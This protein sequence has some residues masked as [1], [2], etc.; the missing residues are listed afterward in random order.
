MNSSDR[1]R[2]GLDDRQFVDLTLMGFL[3]AV[4][5][6]ADALA[7]ARCVGDRSR[8]RLGFMLHVGQTLIRLLFLP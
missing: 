6:C 8:H 7:F 1:Q 4:Q 5:Q 2:G 3:K